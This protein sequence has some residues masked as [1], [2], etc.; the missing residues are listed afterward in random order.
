M[1]SIIH[2]T[3]S[4]SSRKY[5][6]ELKT[7]H[8]D[9]LTLDGA[10][11]TITDL[12]QFFEGGGLF[13]E[14]KYFFIEQLL[15]K[16]KKS[17]ELES[18]IAYLNSS[19]LENNIYLWE[20]KELTPASTKAFSHAQ[21]KVF[22]LPQTLFTFLDALKPKN[23]K[24]LIRLFHEAIN[25]ADPEMVFFMIIRQV[26]LLLAL[27][28]SSAREIDE[29]KRMAPWQRSKLQK[30]AGLFKKEEIIQLYSQ[31]FKMEKGLKTGTL[32]GTITQTIDLLLLS[33]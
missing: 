30:Q 29:I 22:K 8:P 28:E 2:G 9:A 26:R 13:G 24:T 14:T 33:I 6:S 20:D 16:R 31:L 3:D 12:T 17:K 23:G 21:I 7:A 15:G 10:T 19:G 5:F 32:P 27:H 1:I 18:I 25:N 4:A 11:V